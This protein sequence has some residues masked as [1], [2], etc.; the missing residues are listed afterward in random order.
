[1]YWSRTIKD[2]RRS[3]CWKQTALAEVLGV[4]Q[5]AISHWERG[6]E[7]PSIAMQG[8]IKSMLTKA[9]PE[10][11]R[12]LLTAAR[13]SPNLGLVNTDLILVAVSETLSGFMKAEVGDHMLD[14]VKWGELHNYR[15]ERCL[16][17]ELFKGEI[18]AV[19]FVQWFDTVPVPFKAYVIP[20]PTT[21][22]GTLSQSM[23]SPITVEEHD[24]F[25]HQNGN[26]MIT[27]PIE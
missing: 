10:S 3:R 23:L 26:F 14:T 22:Q 6:A 19:E 9:S 11:D 7:E 1:M 5:S 24:A 27:H 12:A 18:A 16:S 15:A 2:L 13:Y 25:I 8:R 4:S 21:S 17:K 20:Q